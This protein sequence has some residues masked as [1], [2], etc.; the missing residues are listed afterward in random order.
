M[1][2]E[3]EEAWANSLLESLQI[4]QVTDK[5]SFFMPKSWCPFH[6]PSCQ[7][8]VGGQFLLLA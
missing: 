8:A 5:T 4:T 7:V 2:L 3:Y 6:Y 1:Y